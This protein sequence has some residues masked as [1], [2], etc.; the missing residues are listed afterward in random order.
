MGKDTR[1]D[2]W[3]RALGPQRPYTRMPG[4]AYRPGPGA[5]E[6]ADGRVI[7]LADLYGPPRPNWREATDGTV[8]LEG[9]R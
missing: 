7:A 6:Y 8:R 2:D 3:Y 4:L 9:V 1:W 5:I